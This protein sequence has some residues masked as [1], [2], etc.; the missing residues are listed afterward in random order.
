MP[1]TERPRTFFP[2]GHISE[3][4]SFR[5]ANLYPYIVKLLSV[6]YLGEHS[7]PPPKNPSSKFRG[8]LC[9]A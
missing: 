8:D 7:S 6:A 4:G 1:E 5:Y 3:A 9:N 2:G